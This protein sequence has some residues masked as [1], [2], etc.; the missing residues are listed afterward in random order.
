M[1]SAFKALAAFCFALLLSAQAFAGDAAPQPLTTDWIN[2]QLAKQDAKAVIAQ[3]D[4]Q[5]RYEEF[6][7]N[8]GDG[9]SDWIQLAAKL[10]PGADAAS[11]EGLSMSLAFAL[12]KNAPA[13]V[14]I[15]NKALPP[16]D[17]RQVCNAPFIEDMVLD[18]PGYLKQAETAVQ[19][20]DNPASEP[21]KGECLAQLKIA[22]KEAVSAA[23]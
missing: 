23:P 2:A 20:V 22:Q 4:A 5:N 10:A 1:H 3:L 9:G 6:L 8:V 15:L 11:S 17:P 13:V 7:D 16:L 19:K 18:I 21:Q 14:G 12:P